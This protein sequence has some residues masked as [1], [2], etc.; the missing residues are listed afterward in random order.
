MTTKLFPGRTA[1]DAVA[2]RLT[3]QMLQARASLP[4]A[5]NGKPPCASD[6]RAFQTRNDMGAGKARPFH[7]LL[8]VARCDLRDGV[9]PAD[10]LAVFRQLMHEVEVIALAEYQRRE[11]MRPLPIQVRMASQVETKWEGR[12]NIAQEKLVVAPDSPVALAD[13]LSVVPKYER[14]FDELVMI[15]SRQF[16]LVTQTQCNDVRVVR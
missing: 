8:R 11:S 5:L 4:P 7:H 16:A 9:P 1:L 6:P 13:F 3:E 15:A 2:D 14:A 10:V 12:L